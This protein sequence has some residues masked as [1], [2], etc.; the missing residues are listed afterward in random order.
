MLLVLNKEQD[1]HHIVEE[2]DLTFWQQLQMV[3]ANI[4]AAIAENG[5]VCRFGRF[6]YGL[7]SG[8][9]TTFVVCVL[10]AGVVPMI[11]MGLFVAA[12][13][14]MCAERWG[15]L[16]AQYIG[17]AVYGVLLVSLACFSKIALALL[18]VTVCFFITSWFITTV[19]AAPAPHDAAE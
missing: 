14:K 12:A 11:I 19:P 1:V 3:F 9:Q 10:V 16:A 8:L 5:M 7:P 4:G 6:C 18:A 13:E 17:S 2:H 15:L